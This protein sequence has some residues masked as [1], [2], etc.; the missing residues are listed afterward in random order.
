MLY[1]SKP[2]SKGE[3]MLFK[4]RQRLAR[5]EGFTLIELLVVIVII[6]ILLAIAV[7]SYLGFKD[8]ANEKGAKAN[9]RAAIPS[10]EA[11]Y[12]DQTPSTYVGMDAAALKAI[13]SGLSDTLTVASVTASTYCLTDTVG[14]HTWSARGPGIGPADYKKNA[15]CA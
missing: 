15:T 7:P 12:S 1:V 10:A 13:D 5:E 9:I 3:F 2:S 4:L 14:D 6:G 11:Y 8:R